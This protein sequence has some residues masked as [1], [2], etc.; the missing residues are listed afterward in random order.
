MIHLMESIDMSDATFQKHRKLFDPIFQELLSE[1]QQYNPNCNVEL[2]EKAYLFGMWAHRNQNRRSGEPYFR[3]CLE[4]AKLLA[5][6]H[7]DTVTIAAGLLH[8]VVEDTVYTLK[9]IK[10]EFGEQIA[11]LVDGVSK[12]SVVSGRKSLSYESRQAETF[13]KMLLSMAK[14]LRVIIIKFADRLHNMRTLQHVPAKSRIRI[15]IETRD[16]Y[17]PLAHRFG[18]HRLKSELEDLAFKYFDNKAYQELKNRLNQKK[19]E[20]E[21]YIRKIITPIM[22]ELKAHNIKAEVQGRPKHLYSIYRKMKLRNKP[23]EEIYD[24]FAIRIIVDKVE[25][26]YYV[27]GIVHNLYTPVYERFKDYIA[28]PK[29]NGYKSL[30]TTVVDKEGHMVEI[31]IRT[32]EMHRIAEMGIAAHWRYKEGISEKDRNQM[33]EQLGWVR[34]FLEQYQGSDMVDAQDFLESLKINLYQDEVFVFTPHGDVIRLPAESTPVDFAFAVHTNIG[35]HCIGAKVNGRIVPL[36]YKLNSGDMVE[37][38]TSTNQHPS[39]DWLTFVKTSKARHHIR[40]YL[41]EVQFE[42]SMKLGEEIIHRYSKR[43]RL[44]LTEQK[45]EEAATKLNFDDVPN[46]KAA[47]G[48][49]EITIEKILSAISVEQP[50]AEKESM[51]QRILRRQK[52]SAV[53]V[54]GMDNIMVHIGKCCQPVPGDDIIGYITRGRGV[55]IHRTTCPNVQFLVEKRDRTI[56]VNWTVET[57]EEFRVQL[58]ILGEDRKNLIRDI[59]QA[60][61]NT[62]TNILN[63]EF[64]AKDKLAIGK[65][66]IEVRNLPHLTRVINAIHKINGILS[67][68]RIDSAASK[69]NN[70]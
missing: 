39:Q 67:V 14:D 10:E 25:E 26:C 3:H 52:N 16:V 24:L 37:I 61:A 5:E 8:D 17:A 64:K 43:F 12:I 60:I 33:D 63:L 46:L 31:Q 47:V 70:Y 53:Q 4:V 38:I 28:M 40:K 36:K 68:E 51:L 34:Q 18:I 30:H 35:M 11:M 59:T 58:S 27:L 56:P 62:N 13:R 15:A 66:I 41:R 1:I 42:H 21:A 54:Q 19:E 7:M 50:R 57:E 69:K 45:L 49:G 48:R 2:L 65:I 23:F 32:W 55:S 20:R 44:K 6:I 9:D 29:I 22:E